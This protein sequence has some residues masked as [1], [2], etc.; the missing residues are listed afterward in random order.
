MMVFQFDTRAY[1]WTHGRAPK[2]WGT[3]AFQVPGLAGPIWAPASNY[4]EAKVWL[5]RHVRAL[6]PPGF[7]GTIMVEVC[8]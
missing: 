7:V 3:W 1:Q 8:T 4:G 6:A 2:G 5:R